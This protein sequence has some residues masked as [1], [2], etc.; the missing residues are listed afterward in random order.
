VVRQDPPFNAGPPLAA[1]AASFV[2]PTES[3][4]VRNHGDVPEI[5]PAGFRLEVRGRVERPL[6]LSLDDLE[7]DFPRVEVTATLQCAGNRRQELAA[8]REIPGELPWGSDA[9]GNA[10][11]SGVPLAAV[12]EAAGAVESEGHVAFAG[13]DRIEKNGQI[14]HFGGSVPLQKA[15]AGE[16]LLA[17]RMNGRPLAAVHG[18]PLRAMVPGYI[19]ARSVKWLGLVTVQEESSENFYQRKSY[20]LF[21]PAI[22][23]DSVDWSRGLE[24]ADYPVSSV[25]CTPAEGAGV[26][27][28]RVE[29]AGYALA[30]GGRRI[31]T[32]EVSSDGGASWRLAELG[33]A[34]RW[35]WRLWRAEVELGPGRHVLAVRARDS[36]G[37]SQP[38]RVD[39]LWN[40]KGYLS[41]AVHRVAVEVS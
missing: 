34:G 6:E 13:L 19:G 39:G 7:R 20:K 9:V 3:F 22:D 40:F 41:S 32:V 12:L 18:A 15:R 8:V 21:P 28:G 24:L 33:E 4:F 27:A 2:T 37:C 30:G 11:W 36:A 35:T 1:L 38:E 17:T 25:I 31:E 5:D 29:V 23:R 26:A 14:I 16:V 10:T